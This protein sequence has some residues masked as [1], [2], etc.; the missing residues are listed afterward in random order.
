MLQRFRNLLWALS[1]SSVVSAHFSRTCENPPYPFRTSIRPA[2]SLAPAAS[3]RTAAASVPTADDWA[4]Q[5]TEN[6]E[7][8]A[9]RPAGF[10]AL[11]GSVALLQALLLILVPIVGLLARAASDSAQRGRGGAGE[12]PPMTPLYV[13]A[14]VIVIATI[15]MVFARSLVPIR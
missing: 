11:L 15:T 1:K 6:Y 13:L 9:R 7:A 5:V 10:P 2:W 4:L 14:V 3:R 12:P 8:R